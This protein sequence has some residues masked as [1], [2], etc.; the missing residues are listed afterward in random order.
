M[1]PFEDRSLPD[2]TRAWR[3]LVEGTNGGRPLV[4]RVS[5]TEAKIIEVVK[6]VEELNENIKEMK[7]T[8]SAYGKST[9]FLLLGILAT[10]LT[11]LFNGTPHK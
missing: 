8:Q 7:K 9:I 1:S 6:D 11:A 2:G 3:T 4:E 5:L 10:L